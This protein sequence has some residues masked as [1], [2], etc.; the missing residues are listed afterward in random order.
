MGNER[1]FR[2][3]L[4]RHR[5]E[6]QRVLELGSGTGELGLAL[7]SAGFA[8]DGLDFCP[9]PTGWPPANGWHRGDLRSFDRYGEYPV[10]IANLILHHFSADE[11]AALGPGLSRARLILA[12]EPARLRRSRFLCAALAPLVGAD[13]VTR[14]DARVSIEAG[15]LRDELPRQ[16]GLSPGDWQWTCS[17]S[18][19][20]AYRMVARRH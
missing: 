8:I 5:A 20:G 15:F 3:Q 19:L 14:H 16:L 11:L 6:G 2:R 13:P 9:R 1:W 18:P 10:V 12:S 17:T 4:Q 7:A